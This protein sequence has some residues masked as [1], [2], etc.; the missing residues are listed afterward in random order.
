MKR[1]ILLCAFL[2][3]VLTCSASVLSQAQAPSTS[4]LRTSFTYQG[5]VKRNG[6]PIS[7]ACDFRFTLWDAAEVGAQVGPA[8]NKD[9]VLVTKG[10]FT[11][12]LDFGTAAFA[13]DA[14][15]LGIEVRCPAGGGDFTPLAPRQALTPTPYSLFAD[16]APWL[17]L[18]GVP[19]DL[20][21]GDSDTLASLS[22]A[23]GQVAKWTGAEWVCANDE[24]GPGGIVYTAGPGLILVENRFS[25]AFAGTGTANSVARSD[26]N[27]DAAYVNE[28]Q[29]D[30]ITSGMLVGGA[31]TSAK[32]ADN[33]ITAEKLADGAALAQ[34]LDDDG[35]GSG[36][37]ADLLD[38]RD[39]TYFAAASHQHDGQYWSLT[40]NAD[41]NSVSNFVGTTDAVSLTLAVNGTAAL[42]LE[43]TGGTPNVIGGDA[44]NYA[45]A[46]VQGVSIGGGGGTAI[47]VDYYGPNRVTDHYGTV[48]GGLANVAGGSGP[49]PRRW[50]AALRTLR[51]DL[52]VQ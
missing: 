3:F 40:G 4:N 14:R 41:T 43:P 28:G 29:P 47:A 13:G 39:S 20:A 19:A 16:S 34:I 1:R 10:L 38:G 12:A 25:V 42:R 18:V 30:S 22:C 36:L 49:I 37:D 21:D 48:G 46:G 5:Q 6:Q 15:W 45:T 51:A 52:G 17:G 9:A 8:V 7:G 32:L 27:H 23:A 24:G 35:T 33:A 2:V 50:A 11:V 44:S 31:V 26:H